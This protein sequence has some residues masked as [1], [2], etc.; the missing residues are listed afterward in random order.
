MS[1]NFFMHPKK[2][3]YSFPRQQQCMLGS[4]SAHCH[5]DGLFAQV[6][7]C[8]PIPTLYLGESSKSSAL[9]DRWHHRNRNSKTAHPTLLS[10]WY[11]RWM[12]TTNWTAF[13]WLC[14]VNRFK[15]YF[16][17]QAFRLHCETP[18]PQKLFIKKVKNKQTHRNAQSFENVHLAHWTCAMI[19]Q[20]RIHTALMKQMSAKEWKQQK[21]TEP[22]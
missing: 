16:M 18:P 15:H 6:Q 10:W 1:Q 13:H 7:Y 19:K 9:M 14:W 3:Q 22:H 8:Q 5:P 12:W 11:Y 21:Y 4:S 2:I 20:P 17:K